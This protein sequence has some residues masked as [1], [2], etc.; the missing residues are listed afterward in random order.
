MVLVDDTSIYLAPLD[1][2]EPRRPFNPA[3]TKSHFELLHQ[4]QKPIRPECLNAGLSAISEVNLLM[5]TMELNRSSF[6]R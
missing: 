6:E 5:W 4:T 1:R 3:T 2:R